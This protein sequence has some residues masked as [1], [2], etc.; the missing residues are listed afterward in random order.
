VNLDELAVL[1]SL[2]DTA[3]PWRVGHHH[4]LDSPISTKRQLTNPGFRRSI[5]MFQ[6]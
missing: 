6:A 2:L 4:Q 5:V 1:G 3:V